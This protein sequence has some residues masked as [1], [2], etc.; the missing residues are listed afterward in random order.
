MLKKTIYIGNPAYLSTKEEQLIITDPIS[1]TAKGRIAIEDI[2]LLLLDNKQI[3]ISNQLLLRLQGNNVALI[4]CDAHHLPFGLMLPMYG[5]TTYSERIK[6]QIAI[7]E[8][9]KKQLWKQTV[10]QKIKNQEALLKLY[11]KPAATM[12][13]YWTSTK[14][15]DS[16][17]CEGKAAVHY[18]KYLFKNFSRDRAGNSPNNMLNFG[19]AILRS[20]V[21]RALVSSGLNPI[22]GIFHKNKYN[23]YCLADD[24]MEPYRPFV[25][26]LVVN[27]ISKYPQ[28][29]ELN[30]T[31]KAHLLAIATQDVLIA[32]KIRPL[33]VAVTTTTAS[34]YKCY[35]GEIRQIKY[36][37]LD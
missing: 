19:Y 33:M 6:V 21:A 28:E 32:G 8:P 9:L 37:R 1:K 17:N 3:T 11:D 34:L 13:D 10:V 22:F 18:W 20:I 15:G 27:F 35:T 16:T 12:E 36:P 29:K 5:H 30:K 31:V 23:P 2:A 14:S 24:I 7:S 4:T 25:D 26:K